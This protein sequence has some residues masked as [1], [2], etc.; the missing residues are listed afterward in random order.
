ML[1]MI[2]FLQIAVVTFFYKLTAAVLEPISDKRMIGCIEAVGE[3][4]RLLMKAIMTMGMMFLITIAIVA[5]FTN[6]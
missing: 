2:P 5:V 1:C 3:G 4:S 6:Q